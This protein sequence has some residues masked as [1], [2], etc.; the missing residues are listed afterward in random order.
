ME[1][2]A[3]QAFGVSAAITSRLGSIKLI[4]PIEH[5]NRVET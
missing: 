1:V 2:F 3:L 4:K 5:K